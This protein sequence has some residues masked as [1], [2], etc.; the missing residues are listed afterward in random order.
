ME[1]LTFLDFCKEKLSPLLPTDLS[2]FADIL[3]AHDLHE[4][5]SL[6]LLFPF[7]NLSFRNNSPLVPLHYDQSPIET[8]IEDHYEP[9][10]D[11]QESIYY[12]RNPRNSVTKSYIH[13]IS[14]K[15]EAQGPKM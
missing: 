3:Q 8:K 13:D 6:S 9:T 1:N 4:N 5:Q 14:V 10:N 15:N 12:D 2:D 11:T 7:P